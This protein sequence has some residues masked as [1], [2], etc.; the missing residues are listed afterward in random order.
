LSQFPL[1][2]PVSKFNF[3]TRN[4]T[5]AGMS[6]AT[7]IVEASETSGALHQATSCL[8]E[9]RLL[10]IMKSIL[11]NPNLTWPSRYIERGAIVLDS[12][13]TLLDSLH[14]KLGAQPAETVTAD[15]LSVFESVVNE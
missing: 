8:N 1:Q 11:G 12:P 13:E 6:I 14:K 15:Q 7:I 4:F 5:M 2:Q 3:P 10:F 9:N